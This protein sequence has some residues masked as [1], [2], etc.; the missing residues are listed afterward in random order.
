L[1][2]VF[3]NFGLLG[4][5]PSLEELKNPKS[6]MASEVYSA[7]GVLLGKIFTHNRVPFEFNELPDHLVNAL[8]ATEDSRFYTH[9]GIDPIALFGV[10]KGFFGPGNRGGGSTISQQLAK[11]LFP[12][13]DINKI[14]L[15]VR[16]FKEWLIAIKLERAFTK[17]EIIASY[18]NTVEFSDNAFGVKSAAKTYFNKDLKKLSVPE[19][20]TLV[21][22][23][24]APYKYNPR[25]HPEASKERRNVVLGKM[26]EYRFITKEEYEAFIKTDIVLDFN[27]DYVIESIAPH[28]VSYLQQYLNPYKY[29]YFL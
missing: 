20:A 27:N 26:F 21:G 12:R 14:Q 3:L 16:K 4:E 15:V 25:I 1:F 28:F 8:I 9:Y 18:F 19:A 6:N 2:F 11:N 13:G 23:L 29:L 24:K 10:V 17:H 22:M 7:D 5:M